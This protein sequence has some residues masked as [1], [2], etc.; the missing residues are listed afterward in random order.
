MNATQQ[1]HAINAE[2]RNQLHTI[3]QLTLTAWLKLAGELGVA[4]NDREH[5]AKK[6]AIRKLRDRGSL[7]S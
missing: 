2:F 6:L 5:A 7:I 1:L 3:N 4:A